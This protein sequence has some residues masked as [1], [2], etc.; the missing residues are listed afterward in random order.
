MADEPDEVVF[1][2][3]DREAV[4]SRMRRLA[5]D[6]QGWVNVSPI[7]PEGVEPPRQGLLRFFGARGPESLLATWLPGEA[8]GEG[9]KP[10]TVGVQHAAGGRIVRRLADAGLPV[11]AGWRVTQDHPTRGL[12][13]EVPDD[14]DVDGVLGW[15][16]AASG[17]VASFPLTGRWRATFY[18]RR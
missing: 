5:A 14:A 16:V 4:V 3:D 17:K 8:A 13:A 1:R 2:P 7:L 12:V 10:T 11:P 6:R 15:L 9:F 18:R